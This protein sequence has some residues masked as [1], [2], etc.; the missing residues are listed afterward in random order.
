MVSNLSFMQMGPQDLSPFWYS[1]YG[2]NFLILPRIPK[3]RS[4]IWNNPNCKKFLLIL[5]CLSGTKLLIITIL[6]WRMDKIGARDNHHIYQSHCTNRNMEEWIWLWYRIRAPIM[7]SLSTAICPELKLVR[8]C[9]SN[10][11]K[12]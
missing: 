12:K 3:L 11:G 7:L 6:Q 1:R 4:Q 9:Y 5:D 2:N 10:R 8:K